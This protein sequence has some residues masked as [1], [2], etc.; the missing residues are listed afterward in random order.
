MVK[1]ITY[2]QDPE[3]CFSELSKLFKLE[4]RTKDE[5]TWQLLGLD[6]ANA[7]VD[8]PTSIRV[9]ADGSVI[10]VAI[11]AVGNVVIQTRQP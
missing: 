3:L 4:P 5:T 2:K 11:V 9:P 8:E 10:D 6:V 7:R 1:G